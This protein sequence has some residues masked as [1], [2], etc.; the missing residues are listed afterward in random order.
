MNIRVVSV[1]QVL[2]FETGKV[3]NQATLRLP[4]GTEV[5]ATVSDEGAN[6]FVAAF[7]K[8]SEGGW[9]VEEPKVETQ[10]PFV[11]KLTE[12][13]EE[14]YVFGDA[15]GG[16]SRAST[17]ELEVKAPP[18]SQKRRHR[19]VGKDSAG[20]PLVEFLDNAVPPEEV[21]GSVGAKDEDGVASV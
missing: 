16:V 4:D 11:E 2:N 10:T 17:T 19:L 8:Q 9:K 20:N 12:D 5:K 6:A 15:P 3:D 18:P 7:A 14:A 21:T 1:G 13:G